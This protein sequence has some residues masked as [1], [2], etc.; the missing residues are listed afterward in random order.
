MYTLRTLNANTTTTATT[1]TK[2]PRHIFYRSRVIAHFD[3]NLVAMATVSVGVKFA[4]RLS[5]DQHR[6][7]L[8]Q[9]LLGTQRSR[10]YLLQK[11]RYSPFCPKF[12]C[13]GNDGQLGVNI[14]GTVK[15][16]DPCNYPTIEPNRK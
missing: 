16:A 12:R 7:P 5:T 8:P 11:P 2:D 10:R 1:A 4:R 6:K 9:T 13:H 15:L 3:P 14:N